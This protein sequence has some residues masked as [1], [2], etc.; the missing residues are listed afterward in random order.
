MNEEQLAFA[1]KIEQTM[2]E[3]L[4]LGRRERAS[5]LKIARNAK[6]GCIACV[7][8][9]SLEAFSLCVQNSV[10]HRGFNEDMALQDYMQ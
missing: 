10:G 3:D 6:R 7:V 2:G 9:P 5:S 4:E 8:R 1:F